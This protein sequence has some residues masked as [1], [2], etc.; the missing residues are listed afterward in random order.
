MSVNCF[1]PLFVGTNNPFPPADG[2]RLRVAQRVATSRRSGGTRQAAS[3]ARSLASAFGLF[4]ASPVRSRVEEAKLGPFMSWQK[5]GRHSNQ[6]L[7]WHSSFFFMLWSCAIVSC[8][9]GKQ[10]ATTKVRWPS[11]QQR[12]NP[13]FIPRGFALFA[14]H[15]LIKYNWSFL[16]L[17]TE[18]LMLSCTRRLHTCTQQYHYY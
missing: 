14:C 18:Y 3:M 6:E 7:A 1:F 2:W 5:I 8:H 16:G 9:R 15:F 11:R 13:V 4:T 17:T 10:E 12:K